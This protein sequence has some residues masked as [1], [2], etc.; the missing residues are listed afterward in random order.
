MEVAEQI[1]QAIITEDKKILCPYCRKIN[2]QL[3]G[4][5][6][7]R[8]YKVRCRGSGGRLEHFFMLNVEKEEK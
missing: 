6:T 2:G 7:I 3:T 5:E 8:N 1:R 4:Q